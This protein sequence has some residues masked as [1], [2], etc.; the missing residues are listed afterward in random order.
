MQP[1]L[2]VALIGPLLCLASA[3]L[4]Q[5]PEQRTE[6]RVC[7]DPNNMPFSNAKAEGYEDK[8]A[9]LFA[10]DL[11]LPI[12]YYSFPQRMGFIRN[13]L[14]YKLPGED[15]PCD[16]VMSVPK[17]YGQVLATKVYYHST[18]ALVIPKGKGMDNVKSQEDF[19]ALPPA[20]LHSLKIGIYDRSPASAWLASHK[21][22]DQG[23]PYRMLNA[24]PD[25]YPG[26]IIED[27]LVHGKLDVAIVWGPIAGYFS[28]RVTSSELMV[29]A[30]KSEPDVK[31]DFEIAMG[32]RFGESAW[33]KQIDALI[34]KD[35]TQIRAILADYGVP[36]LSESGDPVR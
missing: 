17:E 21:L 27:D 9:Q 24:D 29:I 33:K 18:Y 14:R 12:T 32:V 1:S 5:V 36:Q 8:I 11:G 2:R 13:T 20:T 26:Q 35:Q 4:A 16:I 10:K 22:V 19:L 7:K 31:M 28:R 3:V 15:Y 30:L 25:Q 23:V 34:D 6:F